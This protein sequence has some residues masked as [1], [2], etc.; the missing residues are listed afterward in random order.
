MIPRAEPVDPDTVDNNAGAVVDQ[1]YNGQR[2]VT[3]PKSTTGLTDEQAKKLYLNSLRS[4]SRWVGTKGGIR[5]IDA[6]GADV[7]DASSG[8]PVGFTFQ[9]LNSMT[10]PPQGTSPYIWPA[11]VKK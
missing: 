11:G 5:L 1:I 4:S 7:L 8:M 2:K 9:E 10:L 6:N 3:V